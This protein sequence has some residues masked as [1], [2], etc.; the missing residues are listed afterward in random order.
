MIAS[1]DIWTGG[2][3]GEGLLAPSGPSPVGRGHE[4]GGA[5]LAPGWA[6]GQV[7][8]FSDLL[9]PVTPVSSRRRTRSA[10]RDGERNPAPSDTA[11][12]A[13]TGLHGGRAARRSTWGPASPCVCG[14]NCLDHLS[15]RQIF[16]NG[17]FGEPSVF[18][19]DLRPGA[20]YCAL[21]DDA[22]GE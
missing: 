9:C 14:T 17:Q 8:A 4:A 11:R 7:P 2:S 16:T 18:A 5:R 1:R 21:W 3:S 10:G 13:G 15:T 22:L 6:S 19:G 12:W 20:R